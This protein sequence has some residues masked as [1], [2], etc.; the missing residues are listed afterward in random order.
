MKRLAVLLLSG[1]SLAQEFPANSLQVGTNEV[2]ASYGPPRPGPLVT[3]APYSAEQV[4]EY[5]RPDGTTTRNLIGRFARDSQGRVRKEVAY[6]PAPYWLTTIYDPVAGVAYLLDDTA[7]IA[8]RMALPPYD[9][10]TARQP[11]AGPNEES[12]GTQ[13]VDGLKLNGRR[14][15]G[16]LTI[17]LWDSEE[18]Q[19]NVRTHSNNGYSGWLE[20][21]TR[22]EP[23]S[24][25]LR[26]PA[27][28]AVVDE[29]GP[30][31]MT[32]RLK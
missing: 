26:P 3:G 21:L 10:A 25:R 17:E 27:A 22:T 7:K 12:L 30:F 29:A 6:K 31:P 19:I 1:V 8:H 16:R 15:S 18:L 9:H 13:L 2:T 23:D 5:K 20:N 24:S 28:Y 32:I 11:L 4:Q 14:V